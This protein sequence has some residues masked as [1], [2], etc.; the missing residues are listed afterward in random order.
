M[1]SSRRK[2]TPLP[3]AACCPLR[4]WV[5]GAG[6]DV[7]H[8]AWYEDW[9]RDCLNPLG[10]YGTQFP[11]TWVGMVDGRKD[12]QVSGGNWP[13]HFSSCCLGQWRCQE[14]GSLSV[15]YHINDGLNDQF[16]LHREVLVAIGN[17]CYQYCLIPGQHS[18]REVITGL[19][20][21]H[22]FISSRPLHTLT[23]IQ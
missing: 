1:V 19:H 7:E 4:C 15:L 10:Q 18:R 23:K 2:V 11:S 6:D 8:L 9:T 12:G 22:H 20:C 5:Q 21:D 14:S 17:I 13:K 3:A 16:M